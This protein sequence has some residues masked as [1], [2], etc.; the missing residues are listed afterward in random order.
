MAAPND[1]R[2]VF[3]TE[4]F[5]TQAS[6]VRTYNLTYYAVDNTVEMYDLKNKKLFLKRCECPGISLKDL[7]IGAVITIYSRQLKIVDYADTFTK[8]KF[9][10]KRGRTFAM[11]KPDA[12]TSIGKI[13]DIIEQSG[14]VIGNLKMAKLTLGDAQEFYAEHK[15]KPFFTELTNFICSDFVV[16]LELVA[17]DC[18]SRWRSLIG[19]T[20][21]QVARVEAP[22]SIRALFGTEGVRNAVHGSDSSGSALREIEFFFGEKSKLKPTAFF[23][24]C[25]CAIIKPHIIS[26]LKAGKV[27]NNILN[28]GF[29]ISAMQMFFLDRAS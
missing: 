27:I 5:D 14:F 9:E 6:L 11:I 12:Y 22:N 21:C 20:N 18:I 4:W 24:N 28:E 29:E 8:G 15:G 10:V 3:I 16:G 7:F 1:D 23:T 13:I 26:E 19:P 2:Y 17:E 25:T